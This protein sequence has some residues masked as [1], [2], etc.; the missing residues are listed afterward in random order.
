M[1]D[2]DTDIEND[3]QWQFIMRKIFSHWSTTISRSQDV[4]KVEDDPNHSIVS[5][6]GSYCQGF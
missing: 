2:N 4:S 6:G 3:K 1:R 5:L